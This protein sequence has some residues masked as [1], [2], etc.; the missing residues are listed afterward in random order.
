[1]HPLLRALYGGAG[2]LARA[3]V[4]TGVPGQGKLARTINDR[5]G[6]EAR[7]RRFATTGRDMQRPL[8]WFHAPSV[9][10]GLQAMPVIARL[11]DRRSDL[12]IAYTH[13]SPSAAAFAA[14]TGADFADYL[15]FDS[16]APM[17]MAMDTLRPS[18]LVF[19]KLD[20]WPV[21]VEQAVRRGVKLGMISATLSE[22][23][24]RRGGIAAAMTRDAYAA[25]QAVGAIDDADAARLVGI[26]VREA[27]IRVTGDTRYDQVWQRARQVHQSAPWLDRFRATPRV[28][29]VAGSTWPA[30]EAVLLPAWQ[31]LAARWPGALRLIIAPHEPTPAHLAPVET[32]AA[33]GGLR[34]VRLDAD[35]DAS[36]DVVLVDRVGVLGDLYGVADAAF[37]GGGFHG[38]GL[39]SVLE[40]AAFGAP[41]VFGP[42]HT[43]SRDADLLLRDAAARTVTDS[44]S[45]RTTLENWLDPADAHVR[46]E[47]GA[48]A[49]SRVQLGLGAADR[50]TELVLSLLPTPT[51]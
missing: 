45:L 19:S 40:P 35:A 37:V 47:A 28:T 24:G 14:R 31:A 23:S 2:L 44:M 46:R 29:L 34:C 41:V 33:A 13:F 8:A 25:L 26:G 36:A 5:R 12:Q 43:N 32:W 9:G 11:R 42:Q 39:H 48:R 7:Y 10:E 38:A 30:D 3:A 51:R 17:A 21:L 50:A 15:P 16:A 22:G 1:M 20:V 49:R 18:A 4:A 6:L 27:V